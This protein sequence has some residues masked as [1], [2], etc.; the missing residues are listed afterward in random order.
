MQQ[1]ISTRFIFLVGNAT[2]KLHKKYISNL[3]CNDE[4]L[5]EI[6]FYFKMQR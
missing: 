5:A 2:E 4:F 3:K 6:Y 1:R